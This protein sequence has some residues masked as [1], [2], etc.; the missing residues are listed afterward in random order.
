MPGG[1]AGRELFAAGSYG[2]EGEG[3]G[4]WRGWGGNVNK[5]AAAE[6]TRS[7]GNW[8]RAGEGRASFGLPSGLTIS[9]KR[10]K[11]SPLPL[12]RAP[13]LDRG[14]G[15]CEKPVALA[16]M[17]PGRAGVLSPLPPSGRSSPGPFHLGASCRHALP[18]HCDPHHL[19]LH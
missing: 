3:Q 12:V 15:G 13:R 7:E 8:T 9:P 18:S 1:L 17:Q 6:W 2:A 19:C 14:C 11:P 16:P 5:T 10:A 4:A